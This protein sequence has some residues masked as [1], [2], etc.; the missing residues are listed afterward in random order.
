MSL[1]TD[2]MATLSSLCSR[3]F[4]GSAPESTDK[5]YVTWQHV[6]GTS[7][8]YLDGQAA[9][10]RMPEVQI[11]TWANTPMQAFSLIQQI[12]AALCSAPEFIAKPLSEPVGAYDDADI[13]S[14]YLQSYSILGAR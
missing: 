12:E 9:E 2:L 3:I 5:P 8:R 1:E 7:L 14:G 11:N 4:V 13:A 10:K 6:G